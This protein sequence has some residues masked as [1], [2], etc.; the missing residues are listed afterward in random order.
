[1]TWKEENTKGGGQEQKSWN[2]SIPVFTE[3]NEMFKVI[4]K[5]HHC[6]PAV[7]ASEG[8]QLPLPPQEVRGKRC[9]P[10]IQDI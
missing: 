4:R 8:I 9:K 10:F 1:M 5:Q 2:L 7:T 3:I 6:H